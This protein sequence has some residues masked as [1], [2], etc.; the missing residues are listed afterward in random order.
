MKYYM[1]KK[2]NNIGWN[3][4]EAVFRTYTESPPYENWLNTTYSLC[5]C[6]IDIWMCAVVMAAHGRIRQKRTWII[7]SFTIEEEDPGPFPYIHVDKKYLVNFLLSGSGVDAEPKGVLSINSK[8]GQILVHKKVDYESYRVLRLNFEAK[9]VSNDKVDTRLGVES[10]PNGTFNLRI[11]STTPKTDNAEFYLKE[12]GNAGSMYGSI[13]F[14][15][16]M[17]Y[18]KAKKYIILIEA[19]DKGE[20]V[21]LSSTSTVVLNVIDHNNHLP[22]ISGHTGPKMIKERESGVEVLRLQAMDYEEQTSR[23]VSIGVENE[24]PFFFL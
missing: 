9:N 21:Q 13:Y 17:D 18:E 3:S 12:N 16:C 1:F 10:T 23:N 7:D 24:V 15:G 8:T 5:V 11:V 19:K 4:S 2:C 20:K 6:E 22:V 14:K